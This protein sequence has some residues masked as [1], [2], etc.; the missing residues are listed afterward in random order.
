MREGRVISRVHQVKGSVS[1]N[2][3][4]SLTSFPLIEI[5]ECGERCF[6]LY[7]FPHIAYFYKEESRDSLFDTSASTR[8]DSPKEHSLA[9][10]YSS[11]CLF[12]STQHGENRVG[13]RLR[14]T[15]QIDG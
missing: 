11:R 13:S 5:R 9:E 6:V 14:T 15:E 4:L 10:C 2:D 7:F 12:V 8:L 1:N 3:D